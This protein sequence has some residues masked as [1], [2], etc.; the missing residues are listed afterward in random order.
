MNTFGQL[1]RLTTAGESHGPAI[2]AILDGFPAGITI[3]FD[4]LQATMNTRRPGQGGATSPR[5]E[6]D[7]VELLSGV[8]DGVSTGSP[9]TISIANT[10]VRSADYE[11]FKHIYRPSHADFTYQTKYG[12]RDYRGGGR[13]SARE[14]ALRVAAGAL[15]QMALDQLGIKVF[16]YT[17]RIGNV[18]L[19]LPLEAIHF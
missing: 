3:D 15:A 8:F 2:T 4:A 7:H 12:I 1:L 19:D 6:H 14:T 5:C 9:I 10:D 16:A 13:A 11:Q 17:S 18:S